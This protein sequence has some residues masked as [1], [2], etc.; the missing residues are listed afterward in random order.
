[1]TLEEQSLERFKVG[2]LGLL[3]TGL[4]VLAFYLGRAHR[5]NA[6]HGATI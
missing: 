2:V 1:M 5:D 6:A 4:I 3:C